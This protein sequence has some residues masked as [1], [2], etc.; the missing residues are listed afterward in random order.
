MF[1]RWNNQSKSF[2]KKFPGIPDPPSGA[3]GVSN[4]GTSI[5][6]TWSSPPYDGGCMITGYLVEM[7]AGTQPWVELDER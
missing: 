6:I 5:V 3:I 2:L 1:T 4:N 7:K